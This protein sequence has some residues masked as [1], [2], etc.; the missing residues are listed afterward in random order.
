MGDVGGSLGMQRALVPVAERSRPA[1]L[2]RIPVTLMLLGLFTMALQAG[3]PL[4]GLAMLMT[5][6][7]T[8]LGFAWRA[9]NRQGTEVS[10]LRSE[11]DARLADGRYG[12]AR[13][14]YE[15]SLALAEREL[16]PAAPEVLLNYYSLAAVSSMMHDHARAGRYL[17]ELMQGLGDRV[18]APWS[19]HVAWLMRRVAHHHSQQGE[20]AEADR[21]C[22]RALDLVGDAPG[23]DDNSVRSLLDDLAWIQHHAGQYVEAERL[24]REVLAIHEQFRDLTLELAQRPRR[25]AGSGRSPYREPGP[26]TVSTSGG[27]DRAVAF[28]LLGLGWTIY[29]RGRYDEARRCFDRAGLIARRLST[30][31]GE[32]GPS[33]AHRG[34]WVEVSRGRA[35]VAVTL[36]DY[37]LAEACYQEAQ[38][39]LVVE[40]DEVS[41]RVALL[42]DMG[43][44]ARCRER[45]EQAEALGSEAQALVEQGGGMPSVASA[46]HESLAELRRR[47]G[48]AREGQRHIEIALSTA[49]RCLGAEHPRV[50]SILAVAARL[51]VARSEL[52]EAER[53]AR[54]SLSLVE[55]SLGAEH[56][57]SAE[58]Y[59]A[60]GEVQL[61]RGQVGA[62][63]RSTSLA[64]ARRQRALGPEHPELGEILDA[65]VAVL[66]ASAR[67]DEV[68]PL[69]ERRARLRERLDAPRA[70]A[71]AS[72]SIADQP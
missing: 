71:A 67:E 68:G 49:E 36:G 70:G 60:L 16:P 65:Q 4:L 51:H 27:L 33:A 31:E 55:T 64:L 21:L 59:L 35:A 19:G 48:R 53:L 26:A 30:A 13:A 37:G 17:E 66:R 12:E 39:Q 47:Q 5:A 61:A 62:A 6:V 32:D 1:A 10:K 29:E 46:L 25:G 9:G 43:W 57:R 38:R 50:A 20:H 8:T 14:L 56:P 18:P 24:F 54:R 11:G 58:A 15:R 3:Q 69:L 41:Q 7:T 45:Y 2:Y 28:S 34:L 42:V 72:D 23:A 44:L 40:T 22:R 52:H 63:E